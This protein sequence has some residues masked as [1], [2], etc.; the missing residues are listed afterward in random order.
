MIDAEARIVKVMRTAGQIGIL[1][2]IS[3]SSH[4]SLR[5]KIRLYK[6]AVCSQLTYG[7]EVWA[8]TDEESKTI[9]GTNSRMVSRITDK[10]IH[11]EASSSTRTF[12][13]VRWIRGR[14]IQ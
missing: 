13:L 5:L 6:D 7:S 1:R 10:S 3:S 4:V 2:N 8:L 11:E 12:C 14:R 9:N